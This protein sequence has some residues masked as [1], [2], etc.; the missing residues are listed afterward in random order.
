[1]GKILLH[2]VVLFFLLKV[3]ME[4]LLGLRSTIS[5]LA[6][7]GT[8]LTHRAAVKSQDEFGELAHDLNLF[9]DRI[10]H[11]IADL[12]QVLNDVATLNKRLEQ[13]NRQMGEHFAGVNVEMGEITKRAFSSV[14]EKSPLSTEWLGTLQALAAVIRQ[15]GDARFPAELNEKLDQTW[16]ALTVCVERAEQMDDR[17]SQV[18]NGL[19]ELARKL[20]TSKHFMQEMAMLEQRMQTIATQGQTLIGRLRPAGVASANDPSN[21]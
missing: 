14:H 13:V 20:D 10:N 17:H 15:V 18:G 6:K 5:L 8:D 4:P 16:H 21:A 12:S 9:L 3:R 2:T 1:M 7:A 11:V 19:V